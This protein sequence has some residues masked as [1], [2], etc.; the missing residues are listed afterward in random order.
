[1]VTAQPFLL[2]PPRVITIYYAG[3]PYL[4]YGAKIILPPRILPST[5][6]PPPCLPPPPLAP[7]GGGDPGHSG[8]PGKLYLANQTA[9][10]A[11]AQRKEDRA[12]VLL[13]TESD[14]NT[15]SL[16]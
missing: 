12:K 6:F 2:L 15:S 10:A 8:C 9:R 13:S 4:S 7:G 3:N 11:A 14:Y 16:E 1:M 5:Q